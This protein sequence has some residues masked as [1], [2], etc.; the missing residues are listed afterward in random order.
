MKALVVAI[1]AFTVQ[2]LEEGWTAV[3]T[4]AAKSKMAGDSL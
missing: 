2:L 4:G 1:F 3:R